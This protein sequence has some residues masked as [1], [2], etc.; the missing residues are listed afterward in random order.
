MRLAEDN[1]VTVWKPGWYGFRKWTAKVYHSPAFRQPKGRF[2]ASEAP[3]YH[4][5]N[6]VG[7]SYFE[8]NHGLLRVELHS[9]SS[10]TTLY[11]ESNHALRSMCS[12]HV[13]TGTVTCNLWNRIAWRL[14]CQKNSTHSTVTP[15]TLT[16]S[17]GRWRISIAGG[18]GIFGPA[19]TGCQRG[20]CGK[21]R[22]PRRS[23]LN[24][25][26]ESNQYQY[27]NVKFAIAVFKIRKTRQ[28]WK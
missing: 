14:N 19:G 22:L 26:C 3:R 16:R 11:F 12:L 18:G 6:A 17:S 21:Q 2:Q 25:I 9:T 20:W 28:I 10:R 5:G 27:C 15:H 4:S 1:L 23:R 24:P 8:S 7:L 13:C